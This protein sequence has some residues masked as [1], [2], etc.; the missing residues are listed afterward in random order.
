MP[1]TSTQVLTFKQTEH[2]AIVVRR[3]LIRLH[4]INTAVHVMA[5]GKQNM[6]MLP[7]EEVLDFFRVCPEVHGKPKD[8]KMALYL[9][10]FM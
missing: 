5:D 1:P 4:K 6:W 2:K 7:S 8:D 10:C 3:S 9:T